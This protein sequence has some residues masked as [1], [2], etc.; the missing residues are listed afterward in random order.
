M[1]CDRSQKVSGSCHGC[2][3][4]PA[5][6]EVPHPTLPEKTNSQPEA[7]H[8]FSA[9]RQTLRRRRTSF[10][11]FGVWVRRS[12]M[13]EADRPVSLGDL[14]RDKCQPSAVA[15]DLSFSFVRPAVFGQKI[16]WKIRLSDGSK[17]SS[18]YSQILNAMGET[19]TLETRSSRDYRL[20]F[21]RRYKVCA[22]FHREGLLLKFL[23]LLDTR[24]QES[25]YNKIVARYMQ[26]C[27][28]HSRDLDIAFASLSHGDGAS[29]SSDPTWNPPVS[30][31]PRNREGSITPSPPKQVSSSPVKTLTSPLP[32]SPSH[33][34]STILLALR[35][36]REALLATSCTSSSPVFS[37]RVHVFCIRVAILALHPPSYHPPLIHLLFVLHTPQFPLPASELSEMATYLIYDFACRQQEMASAFALRSKCR[38]HFGFENVVVDEILA[39]V[40]TGNWVAFWRVRREVDGYVRALMHWAVPSLRR[41]TLK[42]LGRAYLNC[43]MEWV[44]QSA[45]GGEMG[46]NELANNENIGWTLDGSRV[47]IRKPKIRTS[48]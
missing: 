19:E 37:Q 35:K 43:D 20:C 9:V 1:I 12:P 4:C 30:H 44:L 33:E 6:S 18:P 17:C 14:P 11:N 16:L 41:N 48:E 36:L 26:F 21:E 3:G 24:T 5:A 46:W 2:G 15:V 23:R 7:R 22:A 28:R 25:F 39:A 34:L 27:N 8:W 42:A 13:L 29:R 40:A 45:S 31:Q 10:L 32:P 47:I 38:I